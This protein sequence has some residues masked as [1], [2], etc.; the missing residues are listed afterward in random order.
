MDATWSKIQTAF[1]GR[2]CRELS[3]L[4]HAHKLDTTEQP[5]KEASVVRSSLETQ[6]YV[7]GAQLVHLLS[8][9]GLVPFLNLWLSSNNSNCDVVDDSKRTPLLLAAS[10]G[11][12]EFAQ[13]LIEVGRA[14]I[15]HQDS[16]GNSALI[17][18]SNSGGEAVVKYLL[19]VEGID[20]NQ[21]DSL[22]QTALLIAS[23]RGHGDIVHTLLETKKADMNIR[24]HNGWHPVFAASV[25]GK[26]VALIRLLEKQRARDSVSNNQVK[27]TDLDDDDWANIR[28]RAVNNGQVSVVREIHTNYRDK[29]DLE[30]YGRTLLSKGFTPLTYAAAFGET[31]MIRYLVDEA[32]MDI[33]Q[34]DDRGLAPIHSAARGN[35]FKGMQ[36]LLDSEGIDVQLQCEKGY[37]HLLGDL[38]NMATQECSSNGLPMELAG[39]IGICMLRILLGHA[40]SK[41]KASRRE[42][43]AEERA[44]ELQQFENVAMGLD[45]DEG[46]PQSDLPILIS[47][48]I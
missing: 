23:R 47:Y 20:V 32:G 24:S 22:G 13:L 41:D 36:A 18:A 17:A 15:S 39:Q 40:K 44:R 38:D 48:P 3:S 2:G 6:G 10:H 42:Q 5:S 9:E 30:R 29:A 4:F 33:N 8:L 25:A 26:E 14:S 43:E 37:P 27:D 31:R 1:R 28:D 19:Q 12:K 16:T 34:K 45:P 11:Q 21:R 7:S 46:L 35:S